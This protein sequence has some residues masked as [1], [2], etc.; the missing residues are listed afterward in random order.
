LQLLRDQLL[1]QL[2]GV[3]ALSK[4]RKTTDHPR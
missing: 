1:L 3:T 2:V 4:V